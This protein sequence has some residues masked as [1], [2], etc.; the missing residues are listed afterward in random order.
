MATLH[1]PQPLTPRTNRLIRAY[2]LNSCWNLSE[3]YAHDARFLFTPLLMAE[4]KT[5][6]HGP[7]TPLTTPFGRHAKLHS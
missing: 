3:P 6:Q 2:W 1:H 7:V 4:S 5:Q